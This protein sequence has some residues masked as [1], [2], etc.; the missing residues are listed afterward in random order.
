MNCK[1]QPPETHAQRE[2]SGAIG[3]Q[4]A[5][6]QE[7][8]ETTLTAFKGLVQTAAD[9]GRDWKLVDALLRTMIEMVL[10]AGDDVLSPPQTRPHESNPRQDVITGETEPSTP[11][12]RRLRP[13]YRLRI[14]AVVDSWSDDEAADFLMVGTR[15]VQRRAQRGDLYYFH[16]NRK[17]RYPV[18]QFDRRFGVLPGIREVGPMLPST[19]RPER[20][21]DFMTSRAAALNQLTPAQWLLATRDPSCIVELIGA[22]SPS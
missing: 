13:V 2:S 20:V 1:H 8:I 14:Q 11:Q 19:W 17:R 9:T 22:S 18:W 15:Q 21:Y 6:T 4:D 12:V 7:D 5:P 10:E 3:D 16:V